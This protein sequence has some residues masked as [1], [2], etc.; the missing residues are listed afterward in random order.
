MPSEK[1]PFI[2]RRIDGTLSKPPEPE[3]LPDLLG[4]D[5]AVLATFI[6]RAW[7]LPG[8]WHRLPG[9]RLAL[10]ALPSEDA[11][12]TLR[13]EIRDPGKSSGGCVFRCD[14]VR[15]IID[16]TTNVVEPEYLHE[17]LNPSKDSRFRDTS[18]QFAHAV[19]AT[20]VQRPYIVRPPPAHPPP[21][22]PEA[23][24]NRATPSEPGSIRLV[25]SEMMRRIMDHWTGPVAI[26]WGRW[27]R[28]WI[29]GS[30][31]LTFLTYGAFQSVR[32]TGVV[33]AEKAVAESDASALF[34]LMV[35]GFSALYGIFVSWK[36]QQYGPIRLYLSGFL[37]SYFIWFLLS[38]APDL[39]NINPDVQTADSNTISPDGASRQ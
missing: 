5:R 16:N 29:A 38:L 10:R 13:F 19:F 22:S 39:Y 24:G 11:H 28:F 36:D 30:G 6:K 12:R 7:E 21:I 3:E 26:G 2:F 32:K 31:S 20:I 34:V 8:E 4:A 25:F 15:R 37:L 27:R 14:L 33:T 9:S 23:T 17:D 35:L 1:R 18:D